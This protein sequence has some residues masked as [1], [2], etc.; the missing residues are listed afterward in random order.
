MADLKES[1]ISS[2]II[3]KGSFLDIRKDI[4][5][6]PNGNTSTREWIKHPGAACIIPIMSDGKIALIK[7]YRYPVQSE[8]IELPAGKL[9]PGEKPEKCAN[10]ELEEEI[11]YTADKLTFI[12]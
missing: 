4:V 7:Q 1:K 10:R 12:C 11:G 6:L 3:Y 9:A 8:M 2:E 5:T